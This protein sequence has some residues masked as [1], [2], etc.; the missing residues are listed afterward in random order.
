MSLSPAF[1]PRYRAQ[2]SDH[3]SQLMAYKSPAKPRVR[4]WVNPFMNLIT[5]LAL[6]KKAA[7]KPASSS[8]PTKTTPH[9]EP[10]PASVSHETKADRSGVQ[11]NASQSEAGPS[12]VPEGTKAEPCGAQDNVEVRAH[13]V[14]LVAELEVHNDS[15]SENMGA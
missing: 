4:P 11:N 7:P 8:K 13:L 2:I 3:S 15:C 6:Q 12:S 5:H 1:Y 9:P 10:G 14:Y